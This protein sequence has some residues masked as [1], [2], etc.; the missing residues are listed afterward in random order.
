MRKEERE[1]EM[2][3]GRKGDN[4]GRK[5]DEE[6]R[7]EGRG[8]KKERK[9]RKGKDEGGREEGR[10]LGESREEWGIRLEKPRAGKRQQIRDR[11]NIWSGKDA[12]PCLGEPAASRNPRRGPRRKGGTSSLNSPSRLPGRLQLRAKEKVSSYSPGPL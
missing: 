3:E 5:R 4:E 10:K 11:A 7:K 1:R 6:R 2:K 12:H 8:M 9:R